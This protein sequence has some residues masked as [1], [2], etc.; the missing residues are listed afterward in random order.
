VF[1]QSYAYDR[2]GNRTIDQANT[3]G[4]PVTQFAVDATTNRLQPAGTGV[5]TYDNVGNLTTNTYNPPPTGAANFTYDAESRMTEVKN[6]SNQSLDKYTYDA[7]GKRTRRNIN[8][9]ETWQVYGFD[10]ELLAEY[11]ASST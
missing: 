1:K 6:G 4:L 8:G 2:W 9:V 11:P 5:M 3:S 7:E 10:G